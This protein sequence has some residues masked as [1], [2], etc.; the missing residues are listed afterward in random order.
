MDSVTLGCYNRAW[1]MVVMHIFDGLMRIMG[2]PTMCIQ[3]VQGPPV[4]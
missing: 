3:E 1:G 4:L 2:T